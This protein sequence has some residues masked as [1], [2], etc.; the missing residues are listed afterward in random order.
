MHVYYS[1]NKNEIELQYVQVELFGAVALFT[2]THTYIILNTEFDMHVFQNIQI[3]GLHRG[4][5]GCIS[6]KQISIAILRTANILK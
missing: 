5:H 2:H 1:L 4:L 6:S 3:L